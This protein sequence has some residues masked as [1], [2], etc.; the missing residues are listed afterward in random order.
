MRP[1]EKHRGSSQEEL[2]VYLAIVLLL[3]YKQERSDS[4]PSVGLSDL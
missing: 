3:R 4:K 1:K 2:M